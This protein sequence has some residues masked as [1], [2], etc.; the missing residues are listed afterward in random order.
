VTFA[1]KS[2]VYN[3]EGKKN[4]AVLSHW[5]KNQFS[6]SSAHF[7]KSESKSEKWMIPML[8]GTL[9]NQV[10]SVDQTSKKRKSTKYV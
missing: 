2:F 3:I 6:S 9:I 10:V 4:T 5:I 8:L 1:K 7:A